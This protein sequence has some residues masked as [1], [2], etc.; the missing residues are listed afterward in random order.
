MM[1]PSDRATRIVA[2]LAELADDVRELPQVEGPRPYWSQRP[3]TPTSSES[4]W[5]T[6]VHRVRALVNELMAE[7][8]FAQKLG[9][10]CVDGNGDTD[11]SPRLELEARLGKPDLWDTSDTQWTE[12]DLC[13]FMEVFHDLAARPTR[14]WYH[15]YSNCGFHPSHF[16]AR[17][18]QALYRWRINQLL[19]TTTLGVRMADEGEDVGR[20]VMGAPTGVSDLVDDALRTSTQESRDDVIHAVA[21][22]RARSSTRSDQRSAIVTLAGVLEQRRDLLEAELLTKDEAALFEVANKFDLRH[23]KDNQRTD[24]D[25]AFLEWIFYWYLATVNLTN[26][27]MAKGNGRD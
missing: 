23:R 14:G 5:P 19:E 26:R 3:S 1:N 4:S 21:L 15:S 7:H 16:S 17:S 22:F 18:G 24:Y 2:W 13:D 10:D 11:S 27:L 20:M 25:G 12:D 9:F 6:V 8:Y